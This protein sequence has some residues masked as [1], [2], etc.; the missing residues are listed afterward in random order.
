MFKKIIIIL[1][2]LSCLYAVP[3]EKDYVYEIGYF[4]FPPYCFTNDQGEVAGVF[5]KPVIE[6]L[7]QEGIK[8][9]ATEY[10]LARFYSNL[11]KGK[12]D[13]AP[14]LELPFVKLIYLQGT[15]VAPLEMRIYSK[16]NKAPVKDK[17]DL[18]GK[19]VILVT[20]MT[21]SGWTKYI[22][23]NED[24]ITH[25]RTKNAKTGFKML[26]AGRADYFISYKRPANN[27][28]KNIDIP[29]LNYQTLKKLNSYWF[30]R[31]K[32]PYAKELLAVIDEI[33]TKVNV[34]E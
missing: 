14:T 2:I 15:S 18:Q 32:A 23:K 6:K 17:R 9:N 3:F 29:K 16:G 20:G 7:N 30:F 27:A 22:K 1:S 34:T 28:L 21:Y 19:S 4:H 13:F 12:I 24:K 33:A 11:L 31:K 8:W 26:Q 10:T 25:S 5:M